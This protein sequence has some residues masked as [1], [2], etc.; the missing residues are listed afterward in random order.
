V[1]EATF[2]PS[3]TAARTIVCSDGAHKEEISVAP[4]DLH[5]SVLNY[6]VISGDKRA[7]NVTIQWATPDGAIADIEYV[8]SMTNYSDSQSWTIRVTHL[9]LTLQYGI[10][11]DFTVTSQRCAG[12]L[13][14]KSSRPLRV[15]FA[16]DETAV[17]PGLQ[18]R[19]SPTTA[20]SK[21]SAPVAA[22]LGGVVGG[23]IASLCVVVLAII[24][25]ICIWRKIKQVKVVQGK[26]HPRTVLGEGLKQT[27]AAQLKRQDIGNTHKSGIGA[28]YVDGQAIYYSSHETFASDAP[29][30][31]TLH[32]CHM[33]GKNI[34]TIVGFHHIRGIGRDKSG[35]TYVVDS[36]NSRVIKFDSSFIPTRKTTSIRE[37]FGIHVTNSFVF[38]CDNRKNKMSILNDKLDLCYDIN[39]KDLLIDPTDVTELDGTYFVTTY[40]AIVAIDVEF[41][42]QSYRARKIE[43]L[44]IDGKEEAFSV[45]KELRGICADHQYL[46]VVESNSRLLRLEYDSIRGQLKYA[47]SLRDISPVVVACHDGEV[48]FSRI[49]QDSRCYISQ[50]TTNGNGELLGYIDLFRV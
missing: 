47:G 27:E 6:T 33:D 36:L 26:I 5:T 25:V 18:P 44:V 42:E 48:Y 12:N 2:T 10:H 39:R 32:K 28:L 37:P 20:T 34:T 46:Y 38:I 14:S 41:E 3:S 15:F 11:Y 50:V 9:N 4:R 21:K 24:A 43:T 49:A 19:S 31:Y 45:D 35:N 40:T 30:Q 1:S 22:V 16:V 8:L 23:V 29:A 13:T 7:R 17:T